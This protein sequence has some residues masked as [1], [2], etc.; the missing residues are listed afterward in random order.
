LTARLA[1]GIQSE[2]LAVTNGVE[3]LDVA[4]GSLDYWTF[5]MEHVLLATDMSDEAGLC[6]VRSQMRKE[7]AV[8][9]GNRQ[10]RN[11]CGAILSA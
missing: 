8:P 11:W 5:I 1:K 6:V 3:Y 10:L 9:S 4:M 2:A 7:M